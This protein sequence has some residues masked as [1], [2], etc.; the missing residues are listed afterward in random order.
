M[1]LDAVRETASFGTAPRALEHLLLNVHRDDFAVGADDFRHRE[2]KEAE[3][4][5]DIDYGVAAPDQT[6]ENFGWSMNES[7]KCVVERIGEPPRTS[8]AAAVKPAEETHS[9]LCLENAPRWTTP[10]A[11]LLA[12]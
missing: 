10:T 9:G 8:M 7:A 1:K 5:A 12:A 6:A 4:R 3:T 11:G 2:R